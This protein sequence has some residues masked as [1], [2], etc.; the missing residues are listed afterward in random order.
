MEIAIEVFTPYP[1]L[2]HRQTL[3]SMGVQTPVPLRALLESKHAEYV[4]HV[5]LPP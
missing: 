4:P 5:V 3:P 2:A 1:A